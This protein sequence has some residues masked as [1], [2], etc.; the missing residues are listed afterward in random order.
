MIAVGLIATKLGGRLFWLLPILF[1]GGMSAGGV[2][3]AALH[4]GGSAGIVEQSI[5]ASVVVFGL[6][7]IGVDRVPSRLAIV[8]VPAFATFHGFAHLAERTANPS[9]SPAV[10]VIGL[11]ASSLAVL[12]SGA[13]AGVLLRPTQSAGVTWRLAGGAVAATGL[14]LMATAVRFG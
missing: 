1:I 8:L 12:A 10:Y 5:A 9:E 13:F 4:V 3:A 6:L 7:M 2:A 14:F 11:M